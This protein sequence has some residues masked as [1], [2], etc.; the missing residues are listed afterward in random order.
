M[1][2]NVSYREISQSLEGARSS[3][4]ILVSLWHLT[5][6][7]A[8]L[9]PRCLINFKAIGQFQIQFLRLR[10]FARSYNNVVSDIDA[11]P[12][13]LQMGALKIKHFD[14]EAGNRI[15][16]DN[17]V[18]GN[19]ILN[20]PNLRK[21]KCCLEIFQFHDDVMQWKHF[22][23]YWPLVPGIHQSTV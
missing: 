19:H 23:R 9:L 16:T 8:A 17:F 2:V 20:R 18:S 5:D 11:G 6:T 10:D 14:D 21:N 15:P 13:S 4:E 22:P 12:I 7:S 3:V 1:S